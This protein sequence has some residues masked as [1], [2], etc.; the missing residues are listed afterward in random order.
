MTGGF[1]P[2]TLDQIMSVVDSHPRGAR[3]IWER[4]GC[5]SPESV[6]TMLRHLAAVGRVKRS[7][8]PLPGGNFRWEYTRAA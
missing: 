4:V 1:S 6:D 2:A 7:K 8:H 5:W 3:E